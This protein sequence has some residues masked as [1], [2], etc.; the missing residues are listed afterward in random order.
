[1]RGKKC[2]IELVSGCSGR[3]LGHDPRRQ[4]RQLLRRASQPHGRHEESGD[5]PPHLLKNFQ[6]RFHLHSKI[7]L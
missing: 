6:I 1:M 5:P 4:R 7:R 3:D 2:F